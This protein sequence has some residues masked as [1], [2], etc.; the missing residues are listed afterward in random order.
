VVQPVDGTTAWGFAAVDGAKHYRTQVARDDAFAQ[1]LDDQKT[2]EPFALL[3]L[4]ETGRLHVRVRAIDS[5]GLEGL[6]NSRVV[7]FLPERILLPAFFLIGGR[8]WF[9]FKLPQPQ[10]GKYKATLSADRGYSQVLQE[11]VLRKNEWEIKGMQGGK[12][13]FLKI[14][15]VD[16][17]EG[18]NQRYS[19]EMPA[20]WGT[21]ELQDSV[22]LLEPI[23]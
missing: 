2:S 5:L 11:E 20:K 3:S 19:L 10:A 4:A 12:T 7:E 9:E 21:A 13:Y 16:P 17:K 6:Q 14:E 8:S 15:S 22:A 23:K 18:V 1:I